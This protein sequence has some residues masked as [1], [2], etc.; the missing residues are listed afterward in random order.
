M[1]KLQQQPQVKK[2]FEP[3]EQHNLNLLAPVLAQLCPV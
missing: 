2:A 3:I 1:E